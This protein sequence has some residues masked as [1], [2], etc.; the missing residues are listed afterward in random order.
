MENKKEI[1]SDAVPEWQLELDKVGFVRKLFLARKW[2][3]GDWW[4]VVISAILLLFIIVVGVFPQWFAPLCL[5]R[6]K[7]P[8]V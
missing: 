7:K 6:A 5:G 4:F 3:G 2:Y 1:V 8:L